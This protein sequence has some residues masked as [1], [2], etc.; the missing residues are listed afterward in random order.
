MRI[1]FCSSFIKVHIYRSQI[2]DFKYFSS[3]NRRHFQQQHPSLTGEPLDV[4]MREYWHN[5][6]GPD[7][8]RYLQRA[9]G[10]VQERNKAP[11]TAQTSKSRQHVY[12]WTEK[13]FIP[14]AKSTYFKIFSFKF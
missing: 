13:V 11:P 7:K 9:L 2:K 3:E 10:A 4:R 8:A 1:T 12:H 14:L 5:M 6:T